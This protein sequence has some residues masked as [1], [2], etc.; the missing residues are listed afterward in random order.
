MKELQN[1]VDK[2]IQTMGGYWSPTAMFLSLAEEVGELA[3]EINSLEKVKVKKPTEPDKRIEEEIGDTLFSLICLANH[4][5]VDLADSLNNV[6]KKYEKR[7][8]DR[9]KK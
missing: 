6:I 7:D 3:R 9:Y 5:N 4:Y 2:L 1:A 8:K